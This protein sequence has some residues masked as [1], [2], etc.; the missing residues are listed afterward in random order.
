MSGAI[1]F[2]EALRVVEGLGLPALAQEDLVAALNAARPGPL[3]LF[4][5]AGIDAELPGDVLRRRAA[6]LFIGFC[7]GQLAGDLVDG[8]CD[9]L[10]VPNRRGPGL[11]YLLH[12][13]F[14]AA[15]LQ[16]GLEPSVLRAALGELAISA[17]HHQAAVRVSGWTAD[18][19]KSIAEGTAGRQYVAYLSL[20]WAGTK[21]EQGA[22][23]AGL[24]LAIPAMI[25]SDLRAKRSRWSS[26]TDSD[27]REILSWGRAY[28]ARAAALGL[29]FVALVLPPLENAL[30]GAR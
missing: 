26:M 23:E 8:E 3:G 2:Q 5:E 11:Q 15:S 7:T 4:Y 25:A 21:L 17:A 16:A 12:N 30:D 14:V 13:A 10:P 1:V 28:L 6:A 27:R 22:G 24:A 29:R 20:L 19:Y 18:E 9:Y